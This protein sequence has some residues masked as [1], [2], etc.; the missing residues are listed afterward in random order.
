VVI[1]AKTPAIRLTL[2]QLVGDWLAELNEKGQG[3]HRSRLSDREGSW[4][5][6]DDA[7]EGWMVARTCQLRAL[8]AGKRPTRAE[9]SQASGQWGKELPSTGKGSEICLK[10]VGSVGGAYLPR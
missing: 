10:P 9:A 8:S 5:G 6:A 4:A 7:V 1:Q 2:F 3:F